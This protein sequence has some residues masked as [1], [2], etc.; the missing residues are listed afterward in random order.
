MTGMK[1]YVLSFVHDDVRRFAGGLAKCVR[2]ESA[3]AA[4]RG[5]AM[6]T[7]FPLHVRQCPRLDPWAA[8]GWGVSRDGS[9]QGMYGW[10]NL[11]AL[12]GHWEGAGWALS[13]IQLH[14]IGGFDPDGLRRFLAAVPAPVRLFLHDYHTVCRSVHLL[15]NGRDYCGSA[16]PCPGKCRGCQSRDDEWLPRM[17]ATLDGLGDRLRVAAPSE[18]VASGWLDSWPEFRERVD[19]VPHWLPARMDK[20]TGRLPGTPL[21]LA[22]AGAQLPHKGWDVWC[23]AV[24]TLRMSGSDFEFLYFGLGRDV[25]VGIRTVEVGEGGMVEALRREAVDFLCLWSIWPETY[26]Y[27]YH[28]AVQAGTWVLAP[29]VSGNIADAIRKGGWGSLFRGEKDLLA[30]LRDAERMRSAWALAQTLERPAEMTVNPRVLDELPPPAP[31]GL[32]NRPAHR[33]WAHETVWKLKEWTGHV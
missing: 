24:E 9:W 1:R 15:R 17:K 5:V 4:E 26:S 29:E 8:R 11:V 3:L 14:H 16:P 30:F 2:E 12:L 7:V 19:V 33:S 25:P 32:P 22:F 31:L 20:G 27:V 13:E 23:R 18:S 21:K 10:E 28:E 6:A